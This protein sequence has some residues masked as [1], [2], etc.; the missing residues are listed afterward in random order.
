MSDHHRLPLYLLDHVL[1]PQSRLPLH[2]FEPKYK[3]LAAHCLG[4]EVPFG[5]LLS[6]DEDMART[7]CTAD[8]E[9]VTREYDNGELDL[10]VVGRQRFQ[11]LEVHQTTSYL[12][13]E[14]SLIQEPQKSASSELRERAITQHMKLLEFAGRT[15]RP[16]VY[17]HAGEISYLLAQNAGMNSEQQQHL[18][19]LLTE[20]ERMAY[21][22][23]YFEELLPQVEE[24]GAVR[25]RIHSNGHFKD[26]P[27]SADD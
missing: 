14:V 26:F 18:L 4:Q 6:E 27:T 8:I 13:A 5:V 10:V 16:S 9:E 22:V 15:V 24:A 11:V 7:G 12:T 21:L 17:E 25:R 2:V 3:E 19:E 1:Y 23:S 20:D